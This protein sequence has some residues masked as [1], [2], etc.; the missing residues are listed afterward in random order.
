LSFDV[1]AVN[2][3]GCATG[4]AE[5]AART[6]ALLS[7]LKSDKIHINTP[8]EVHRDQCDSDF[9]MTLSTPE[10]LRAHFCSDQKR[11]S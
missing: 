9:Q 3:P 4:D 11:F 1:T 2:N 10:R 6:R 8:G 5:T 7:A